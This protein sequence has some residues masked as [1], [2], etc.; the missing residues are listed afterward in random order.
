MARTASKPKLYIVT[1]QAGENPRLV[2]ATNVAHVSKYLMA[3]IKI[4]PA[5]MVDGAK[6][7]A[8]GITIETAPAPVQAG[9]EVAEV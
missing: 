1:N 9:A 7:L 5:T 6:L 4:A 3:D 2:S 8:A